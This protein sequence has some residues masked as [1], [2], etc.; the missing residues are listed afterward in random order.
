MR[1]LQR[2]T[3]KV[4]ISRYLGIQQGVDSQGRLTGK[5]VVV[6]S[7]PE[8]F[9]PS[10]TIGGGESVAAYYGIRTDCDRVMV[11]DD[12]NFDAKP[13]DVFWIDVPVDSRNEKYDYIATYVGHKGHLTVISVR[14]IGVRQ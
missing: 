6:R 10:V 7:E 9:Y 8:A 5:D 13:E 3:Q 14:K 12:I 11:I 4:Y 2:D 1:L